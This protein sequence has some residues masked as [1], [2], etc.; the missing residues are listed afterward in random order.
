MSPVALALAFLVFIWVI[1]ASAILLFGDKGL[2]K[3]AY[4][5]AS[6]SGIFLLVILITTS[7]FVL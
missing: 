6:I 5:A 7:R 4:P 1:I 2:P 3:Y